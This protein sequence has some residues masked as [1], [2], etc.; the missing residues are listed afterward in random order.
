[1]SSAKKEYLCLCICEYVHITGGKIS[2]LQVAAN[3]V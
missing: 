2:D 1:M 3:F